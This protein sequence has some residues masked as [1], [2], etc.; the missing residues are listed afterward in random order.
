MMALA[1]RIIQTNLNHSA[2]AQDLL[3]QTM[4]ECGLGLAVIAEPYRIP[5]DNSV[6][7][8]TARVA[9]SRRH[10]ARSMEVSLAALLKRIS[11][12]GLEVAAHKTEAVWLHNLPPNKRPPTSW[13]STGERIPVGRSIKYLGVVLDG[14][15]K[16][17]AH[18]TQSVPRV[19]KVVLNLGRIMPNT[20]EP[21]GRT[22]RPY[23]AVAQS[24]ILYGAPIWTKEKALTRKSTKIIRSVQ[25]RMAIRLIRA[26]RTVSEEAAL[27]FAGMIPYDHLAR[28]YAEA[29]WESWD[30]NGRKKEHHG[31]QEKQVKRLALRRA[32]NNWKQELERTGAARRRAVGAILPSWEQWADAGPELL[33]YRI[34]QVLT[35]HGCFGEYLRRIGAEETEACHH[36][37]TDVDSAQHTV[38]TCEA[39]AEHRNAL[40]A[41]IGSD[42]APALV[43]ALLAGE[44]ERNAI[45]SFCEEVI[46]Q[47][48]KAEREREGSR[49]SGERRGMCRRPANTAAA[50]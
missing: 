12:L 4:A 29:Y 10:A 3:Q 2:R 39:F 20:K 14:R 9:I 7:D 21:R 36:C 5:R 16:F 50:E 6:G 32:R 11:N 48:E 47:K 37:S 19:E 45:T 41:V 46:K 27:T 1:G 40:I 25:R 31:S 38:E 33:S 13:V 26:Y 42:L 23:A 34:T 24:M 22:R 18:F 8:A 30:E 43:K 17:E 44:R 35:G 28:A 49:T 15:R